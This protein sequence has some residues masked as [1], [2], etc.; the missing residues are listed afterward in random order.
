MTTFITQAQLKTLAI[1]GAIQKIEVIAQGQGFF[2][3]VNGSAELVKG[4]GS[5][6]TEDPRKY[7]LTMNSL[8][9]FLNELGQQRFEVDLTAWQPAN[10]G[11]KK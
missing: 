4:R 2:V 8:F 6:K 7:Y 5:K 1:T 11:E 3:R 9:L 10:E